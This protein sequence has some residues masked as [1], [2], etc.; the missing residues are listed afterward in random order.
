LPTEVGSDGSVQRAFQI[1]Q[2]TA[3]ST[4]VLND[5]FFLRL[6]EPSFRGLPGGGRMG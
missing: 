1:C 5:V 4:D 6:L 3:T 2:L